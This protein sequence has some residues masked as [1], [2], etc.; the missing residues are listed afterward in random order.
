MMHCSHLSLD[1]QILATNPAQ[2]PVLPEVFLPSPDP[3]QASCL[4][5]QFSD[6]VH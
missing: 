3:P 5:S 6:S 2:A 1:P 4:V